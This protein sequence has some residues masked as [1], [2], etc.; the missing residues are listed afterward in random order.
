MEAKRPHWKTDENLIYFGYCGNCGIPHNP[1]FVKAAMDC[2]D[3]SMHRMVLR[4]YGVYAEELIKYAQNKPGIIVLD[5]VPRHELGFIDV[6]LVTLLKSWTH[7][8]VPSKAVSSICSGSAMLFCGDEKSD[9]WQLLKDAS[10]FVEDNEN[11]VQD[12]NHLMTTINLNDIKEKRK[13]ARE[14]T[15]QLNK[16]INNSYNTIASWAQ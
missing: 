5:D 11:M 15:L 7:I 14:I 4:V 12:L 1:N 2:I 8:A 3:P 9:N 6:H 16:L 13:Q 10:W